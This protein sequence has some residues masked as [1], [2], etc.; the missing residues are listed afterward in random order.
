MSS[1]LHDREQAS[2]EGDRSGISRRDLLVLG[3]LGLAVGVPR[4]AD[5][6]PQGQMTWGCTSLWRPL[7]SIRPRHRG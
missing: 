7:G 6:E 3:A 1:S 4:S 2:P 5:A